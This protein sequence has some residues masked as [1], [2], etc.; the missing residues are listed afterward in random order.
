MAKEA[1]LND[2]G[3]WSGEQMVDATLYNIRRERRVEFIGEG[4]RWDDLKRW[5]SW[6]R[7]FTQPFIVEGMNLWDNAYRNYTKEE[8]KIIADGT[9][10]SNTSSASVSKYMRP[11]QRWTTNNQLY[12]GYTWRKAYYLS[13]I[14]VEDLLLAHKLYQNPYWPSKTA[15]LA[16]E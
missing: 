5:R 11:L 2:L 3:V 6:D 1:A 15:G 7:L 10:S 12:N 9:T 8:E 16:E 4:M 14:G 13:P